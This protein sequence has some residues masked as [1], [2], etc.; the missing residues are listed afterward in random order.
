MK[1]CYY[2]LFPGL[3]K[4]IVLYQV[5]YSIFLDSLIVRVTLYCERQ[6]KLFLMYFIKITLFTSFALQEN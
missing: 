4:V 5:K 2:I 3:T 6:A 1:I